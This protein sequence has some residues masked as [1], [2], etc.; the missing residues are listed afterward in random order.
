MDTNTQYEESELVD[1]L[2]QKNLQAYHY[3]YDKYAPALYGFIL[4]IVKDEEIGND[5]LQDIFTTIWFKIDSYDPHKEKLFS[6]M[7]KIAR[8]AAIDQ[9]R[10]KHYP[11]TLKQRPI[12]G[13]ETAY[14]VGH[15]AMDNYGLIKPI[16]KL[17][18]E[19]RMLIDLCFY[20]GFSQDQ[21]AKT[22]SIPLG[23]VKTKIRNALLEL[24]NL[25]G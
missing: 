21:I 22:L 25:L 11:Q 24:R 16:Q 18:E 13:K 2:K 17:K 15:S 4:Q 7:L 3:F 12:T 23:L 1:L 8:N 14:P 5:V 9:T 6:W 10:S 19:N 20:R